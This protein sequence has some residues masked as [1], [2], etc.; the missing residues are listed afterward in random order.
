MKLYIS[1]TQIQ[2]GLKMWAV[3]LS[4]LFLL[5]TS[6]S[7]YAG[8][9]RYVDP[10]SPSSGGGHTSWST[11]AHTIREG[12]EAMNGGDTLIIRD[13]Y[14]TG[15]DNRIRYEY[16]PDGSAGAY[17]KI[18]AE[19]DFGVIIDS[20]NASGVKPCDIKG[21]YIEL[22][23]VECR[24]AGA[25]GSTAGAVLVQGGNYIKLIRVGGMDAGESS[26]DS[27]GTFTI[28]GGSNI[29]VEECYAYGWG[30]YPFKASSGTTNLIFRRNVGR[31]D[32][33][34]NGVGGTF[35]V[36]DVYN[37][38]FQNNIAIDMDEPRH[39]HS[40][41][42]PMGGYQT[43]SGGDVF[44]RGNIAM[45][46]LSGNTYNAAWSLK[47]MASIYL[48][49][50]VGIGVATG[51]MVWAT[52][53][54]SM[55]NMVLYNLVQT[56]GDEKS[57]VGIRGRDNPVVLK[58][59]IVVGADIHGVHKI[60]DSSAYN[61]YYN[62]ANNYAYTNPN[63]N[64]YSS[65]NGN[66]INPLWSG[67]NP[68]GGLKY[69]VRIEPG[70]NLAGKGE[71][72]AN[73][74]ANIMTKIGVSGTLYGEPGYKDDTGESLWPFPNEDIIKERM[75]AYTRYDSQDGSYINGNRGFASYVSPFGTKGGITSYI[76]ESLGNACPDHICGDAVPPPESEPAPPINLRI[77]S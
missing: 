22:R 10:A 54:L 15:L 8:T 2:A 9:T 57:G 1:G 43:N 56:A 20:E 18:K 50:N 67:S 73:I 48:E 31:Q 47:D 38:E 74:G 14:Y 39:W 62:N 69:P 11:A 6:A 71:S 77:E 3:Y 46:I 21:S 49:N 12:L 26:S 40:S 55:N 33:W 45:N 37:S 76:W 63:G 34:A 68:Q 25:G 75:A 42:S 30:R 29:L 36:Y 70:S 64:D 41:S 66:A 58:N 61:V 52:S 53:T 28:T 72:G 16:M 32:G 51:A 35:I 17:T 24:R 5:M 23:G 27:A 4:L 65:E 44:F 19:N 7:A 59:S 60:S 13:G